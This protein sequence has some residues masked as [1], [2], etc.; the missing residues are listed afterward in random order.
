MKIQKIMLAAN[1]SLILLSLAACSALQPAATAQPAPTVQA[2]PGTGIQYHFVTNKLLVP[3]SQAEADAFALNIDGDSEGTGDNLFGRLLTLL[4]KAAPGLEAQST[5]DAA[6]A[7][8]KLVSLHVVKSDDRLN[9]TTVSWSIVQGQETQAPP[10]F[11]GADQF[12]VDPAAPVNSPIVGALT[13]GHFSGGPGAA[14]VRVFLFNKAVDVDLIGLRLEA[15]VSAQGCAN[16]RLGGGLTVEEF[17]SKLLPAIAE[18]LN[19]VIEANP[20]AANVLL[21]AF[22][23]NG[24]AKISVDELEKNPALMLAISPDLDL[25]DAS[26][27]FNPGQDGK[28]DAYSV[29]LGF[30][31]VPAVFTAVGD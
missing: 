22:D 24:D 8:G 23:S 10:T 19:E 29:G 18:G 13:A 21:Q 27:T 20:T 30:T 4:T 5:L 28:K 12:T 2:Q 14:R 6:V 25:L 11:D 15:D 17:R 9:D 7:A 26:G 3:T 31:C 1:S 16:G